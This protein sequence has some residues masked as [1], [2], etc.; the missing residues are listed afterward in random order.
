MSV[1]GIVTEI[2]RYSI[3]DGPGI[4]TVVFLKGCPIRC[5]WCCNPE[6]FTPHVEMGYFKDKC[7]PGCRCT[8]DCPYGA[9]SGDPANGMITNWVICQ[10]KCYGKTETFPCTQHCYT[11]ARKNIGTRMTVEEVLEEVEKDHQ[12]YDRSEGGV[13]L[14]GGEVA[15]QPEFTLSLLSE[16]K[17]RWIDTAIET[18]GFGKPGFYQRIA[19]YLDFV[20]LDIKSA[21]THKNREWTGSSNQVVF[22]NAVILSEL[23]QEFGF[24]L[25]IRTPIVPGFN[26]CVEDIEEIASFVST[27]LPC[28]SGMELLPYHKLGRGKYKSIGVEYQLPSME[29]P[30]KEIMSELESVIVRKNIQVINY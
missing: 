27:N 19:P 25:V 12:L 4:R 22:K 2:E 15:Y 3:H 1:S 7:I 17:M 28:V 9:I 20:F 5:R 18:N 11:Q 14:T 16:F 13:T 26:D 29:P 23:S 21:S 6:T 24:E 30:S 8:Q 10:Q